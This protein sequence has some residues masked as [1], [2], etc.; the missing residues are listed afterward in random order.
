MPL[1]EKS[2]DLK[3][4]LKLSKEKKNSRAALIVKEFDEAPVEDVMENNK[5]FMLLHGKQVRDYVAWR[6]E[7]E[8]RLKFA[9]AQA[10]KVFVVPAPG[11][12]NAWNNE[13]ASWLTTNLR[14]KRKHRQKQLWIQGPGDR[15]D[16]LSDDVGGDLFPSI[17]RW[18]KDE[19]WWDL[20]GDG[21][22]DLI[23]LDEFRSQKMITELNPILSGDP[24]TLDVG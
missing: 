9:K 18:P 2:F 3:E 11:Y 19:R 7:R 5:D 16:H 1:N 4:F 13:I 10:Q 15:E 20:Y 14:Q 22:Y 8:R 12:F 24:T 23:V 6:Q 21:Q 17:Y